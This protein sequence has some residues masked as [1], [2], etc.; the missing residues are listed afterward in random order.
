MIRP[1]DCASTLVI[2]LVRGQK[3]DQVLAVDDKIAQEKSRLVA[4]RIAILSLR[5]M[6]NW[7]RPFSD[8]DSIVI[9]L[10]IAAISGEKLLRTTLEPEFQNLARPIPRQRL[11][12]CNISSIAEATGL[13]RETTRRKVN[14][15]L[16]AGLI[17]RSAGGSINFT[18]GFSQRSE[19]MTLVRAQ[20]DILNRTANELVRDGVLKWRS[21]KTENK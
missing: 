3:A 21:S 11:T 20:L 6:E 10:A 18:P 5:S 12:P 2:S 17:E 15:L 7:R 9:V 8:Y 1:R 4:L 19:P 16:A 14:R 13:N